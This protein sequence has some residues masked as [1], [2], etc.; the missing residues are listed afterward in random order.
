[1]NMLLRR[2]QPAG[3]VAALICALS[4]IQIMQ[5]GQLA[6]N[7]SPT[8]AVD[9][10]DGAR[11]WAQTCAQCHSTRPVRDFSNAEWDVI[12]QHMQIMAKLT[13]SESRAIAEYLRQGR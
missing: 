1:M 11:L 4:A 12:A 9:V 10:P 2:I 6:K 5:G 8:D 13:R 7:P 3:I